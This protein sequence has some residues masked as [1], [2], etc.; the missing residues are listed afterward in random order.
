MEAKKTPKKG[1]GIFVRYVTRNGKRIY[2]KNAKV[3]HFF[4]KRKK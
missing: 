2:P 4:P 3:L 1:N